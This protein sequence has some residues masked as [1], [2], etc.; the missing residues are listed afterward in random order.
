[1]RPGDHVLLTLKRR[2][3]APIISGLGYESERWRKRAHTLKPDGTAWTE[4][5][6]KASHALE[7]KERVLKLVGAKI[8]RF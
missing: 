7:V 5:V 1:M 4:A 8:A 3:L 6:M 2:D